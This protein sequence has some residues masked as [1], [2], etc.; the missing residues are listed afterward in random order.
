MTL[1]LETKLHAETTLSN[2]KIFLTLEQEATWEGAAA[3]ETLQKEKVTTEVTL[4]Q[5]TQ[6]REQAIRTIACAEF[7]VEAFGDRGIRSLLFESVES[8]LND[9]LQYHLKLHTAGEAELRVSALSALK[10]GAMKEKLSFMASWMWGANSYSLGS[11]GQGC[12][13]DLAAFAALQDLAA[14]RSARPIRL[15][16]YDEPGDGLDSLGMEIFA[17][18]LRQQI[19]EHGTGLL[20]THNDTLAGLVEPDMVLTAVLDEEGSHLVEN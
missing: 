15:R 3:L 18:W 2:A 12:R 14:S 9:R 1:A 7:W 4:K 16:V 11:G 5:T 19:Q 20:I 6:A 10:S 13:I 8:F 17:H